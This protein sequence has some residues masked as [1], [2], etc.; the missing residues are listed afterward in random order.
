MNGSQDLSGTE[1][2]N[3]P[4]FKA[5]FTLDYNKYLDNLDVELFSNIGYQWQSKTHFDLLNS[6]NS[7]IGSYGIANFNIGVRDLDDT[8]RVTLFVNN[9][10]DK[11]YNTGVLDYSNFFDG[12]GRTA[13]GHFIPRAA[14]R[15]FGLRVHYNF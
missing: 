8:Y 14:S 10:T 12:N 1:L 4:D 2:S 11:Y 13:I 6:P 7:K 3:S 5:S 15:Y 9:L